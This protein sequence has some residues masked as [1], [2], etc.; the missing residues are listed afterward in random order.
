MDIKNKNVL[1]T[2]G[3]LRIGQALCKAFAEAGANVIIHFN[4]SADAALRLSGELG[5]GGKH[6]TVCCDFASPEDVA[7]L[8]SRTGRIDIL[9]NSASIFQPEPLTSE[10][11][12][13]I[14]CL[15][16]TSP[17]PRD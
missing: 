1:I 2:G 8:C 12:D 4:K 13:G 15:L 6:R 7:S 11:A 3:A 17:S 14:R 16:Y 10:N 5:G 9:I